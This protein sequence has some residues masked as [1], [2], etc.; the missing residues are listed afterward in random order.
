MRKTSLL[1]LLSVS[2]YARILQDRE[3]IRG[4]VTC[5]NDVL[6]V[7][8]YRSQALSYNPVTDK[9]YFCKVDPGNLFNFPSVEVFYYH[10]DVR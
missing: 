1:L 5:Q 9:P 4:N 8:G 2:M 7:T 10:K 3:I 6:Y